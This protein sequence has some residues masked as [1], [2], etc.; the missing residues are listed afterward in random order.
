M[1]GLLAKCVGIRPRKM[2][3]QWVVNKEPCFSTE[4]YSNR[5]NYLPGPTLA[6][7]R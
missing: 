6:A 1:G 3:R 4:Y 5:I 2:T 7:Q